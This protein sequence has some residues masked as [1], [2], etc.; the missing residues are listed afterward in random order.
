MSIS[1]LRAAT[2]VAI[3]VTAA[4]L[5]LSTATPAQAASSQAIADTAIAQEGLTACIGSSSRF[6]Q[7]CGEEW[8]AYFAKWVWQVNGVDVTGIDG[9]ANSFEDAAGAGR[10]GSTVHYEASY[11][12]RPGDVVTF[13][14]YYY[15]RAHVGVVTAVYD[16]GM[17]EYA[18]GNDGFGNVYQ[19]TVQLRTVGAPV[20]SRVPYSSSGMYVRSYTHPG[21]LISGADA[22][23]LPADTDINHDGYPDILG[24]SDA[25]VVVALNNRSGGFSN[26]YLAL[27]YFGYVQGGW[28]V[29]K[30]PRTLAD[31]NNDGYPDIVGFSDAGVMVALNN[32]SGGFSNAYLAL[33]YFGY[34]Q[35]GWRVDKHPRAII[36]MNH[37]GYADIVGYSDAGVIVALNDRTGGFSAPRIWA[38]NF[39][40]VQGGWRVDKHL[41]MISDIN[42]DGYPDIVGFADVGVVV[43]FNYYGISLWP[44]TLTLANFGYV[45]GG[46]RVDKH[47]RMIGQ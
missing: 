13:S 18:S 23:V 44:V 24:F 10:N 12:P 42:R 7:G 9:G 1:S 33:S 22:W 41:R 15:L 6:G 39:G 40:Y 34:V 28:R 36:D 35:G 38:N 47:P 8:C 11:E 19:T 16:N 17:I 25:G 32:R 37:D 30:H 43:G 21:G 46:W 31:V 29:D 4:G 14:N 2:L 20:G 45:Q 26:A 5:M 3:T 27:P